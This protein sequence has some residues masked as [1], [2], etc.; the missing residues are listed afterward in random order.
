[1]GEAAVPASPTGLDTGGNGTLRPRFARRPW[2]RACQSLL[3]QP[4]SYPDNA[5]A[6]SAKGAC[7]QY[8]GEAAGPSRPRRAK[9]PC[10]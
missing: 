3:A 2:H 5:L 8:G 10:P 4:I 9:H 1:M 6:E 7:A